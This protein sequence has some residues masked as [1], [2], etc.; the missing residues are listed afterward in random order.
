VPRVPTLKTESYTDDTEGISGISSLSIASVEYGIAQLFPSSGQVFR[1]SN[2][3]WLSLTVFP[4][5]GEAEPEEGSRAEV[6]FHDGDTML[7][8]VTHIGPTIPA[9]NEPTGSLTALIEVRD[10][11]H[12]A[13]V[14]SAPR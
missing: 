8:T 9:D 10:W 13:S 5:P 3:W 2:K 4:V 11:R 1:A 12:L 7:G 14:E 6:Q